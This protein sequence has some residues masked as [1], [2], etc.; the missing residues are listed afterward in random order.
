MVASTKTV[1]FLVLRRALLMLRCKLVMVCR[2]LPDKAVAESKELVRSALHTL[3]I[4][5][6]TK[7]LTINLAPADLLKEGS[8]FD[9]PIALAVL[10]A[11]DITVC[12]V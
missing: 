4:G 12:Y 3:G 9:L 11:M 2:V 7:R 5:L 1:T 6:P 10:A 8:H